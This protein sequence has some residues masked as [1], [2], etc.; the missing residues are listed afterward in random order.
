ML[1]NW[2]GPT[3]AEFPKFFEYLGQAR[4]WPWAKFGRQAVLKRTGRSRP[5]DPLGTGEILRRFLFAWK[6][7]G[8]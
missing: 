5:H 3:R 2:N 6:R 4:F 8:T 7:G 1:F